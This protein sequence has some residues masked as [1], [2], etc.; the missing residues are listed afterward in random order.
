[1]PIAYYYS[2]LI[3][4]NYYIHV[5]FYHAHETKYAS[6]QGNLANFCQNK[7]SFYGM[8]EEASAQHYS[9]IKIFDSVEEAGILH[10]GDTRT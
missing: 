7:N 1:M 4:S 6:K 5:G 9:F 8:T 2:M 10:I 3:N